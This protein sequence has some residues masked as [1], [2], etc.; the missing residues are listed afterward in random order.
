M[1]EHYHRLTATVSDL[2]MGNAYSFRVFA[3]N[4]VGISEASTVTKEV[5]TI[6]KTGDLLDT[7]SALI[8]LGS[9][10][11][12]E[13]DFGGSAAVQVSTYTLMSCNKSV[14]VLSVCVFKEKT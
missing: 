10:C 12:C 14:R 4:Q 11:L 2:I 5:A 6:Q 13:R 1:L 3:E 9:V 8:Y 7:Y